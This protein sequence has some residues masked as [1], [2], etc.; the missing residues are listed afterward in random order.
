MSTADR[1][2]TSLKY[3]I[4]KVKQIPTVVKDEKSGLE[5]IQIPSRENEPVYGVTNFLN[6]YREE[7]K[8]KAGLDIG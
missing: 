5:S 1:K 3:R 8:F 7:E 2:P 4:G 6:N